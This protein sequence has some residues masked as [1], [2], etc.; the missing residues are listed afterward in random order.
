MKIESNEEIELKFTY[1]MRQTGPHIL[2]DLI[3]VWNTSWGSYRHIRCTARSIYSSSSFSYV[4]IENPNLHFKVVLN[5]SINK[6]VLLVVRGMLCTFSACQT[7]LILW[8]N[9][10]LPCGNE[11]PAYFTIL[12]SSMTMNLLPIS[13]TNVTLPMW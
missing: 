5:S 10:I 9:T 2:H 8:T 1:L 13:T 4:K 6:T 12:S 11:C 3:L 7:S